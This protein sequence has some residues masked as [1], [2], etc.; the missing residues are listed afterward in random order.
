VEQES[1]SLLVPPEMLF[2]PE[3]EREVLQVL[4]LSNEVQNLSG[5]SAGN[6]QC[7]RSECR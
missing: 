7:E 2:G 3:E 1:G 6:S 4:E 5:R